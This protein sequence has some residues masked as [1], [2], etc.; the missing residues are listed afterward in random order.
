MSPSQPGT[1]CA[2]SA[3]ESTVMCRPSGESSRTS[4]VRASGV[5]QPIEAHAEGRVLGE[6]VDPVPPNVA[7]PRRVDLDD[8]T[9]RSPCRGAPPGRQRTARKVDRHI[10][11]SPARRAHDELEL[12]PEDA[13]TA[14][15]RPAGD[16]V[17]QPKRDR[18]VERRR[19]LLLLDPAVDELPPARLRRARPM[20]R[21]RA[22]SVAARERASRS[23][24]LPSA[25]I[26]ARGGS[27]PL[28]ER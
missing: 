15:K 7:G 2:P 9:R 24:L 28:S 13:P 12:R 25:A 18:L 16:R 21:P 1:A 23:S 17:R 11:L 8:E 19:H 27:P 4:S 20:R 5:D 3:A 26:R 14:R 22:P 6:L 10:R